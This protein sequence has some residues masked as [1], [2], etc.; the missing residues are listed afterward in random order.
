ME[1]VYRQA[2]LYPPFVDLVVVGFTGEKETAVREGAEYFLRMFSDT[3]KKE[4]AELPLRVLRPAPAAVARISNRYRYKLIIKCKN[5]GLFRELLTRNM[6]DFAKKKEYSS[7]TV[8]ADPNPDT[9]L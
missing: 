6:M 3:A 2:M 1:I 4:Y 9:I 7:V 5:T 8:F